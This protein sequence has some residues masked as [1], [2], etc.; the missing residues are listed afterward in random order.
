MKDG[1][2]GLQVE[3]GKMGR[4]RRRHSKMGLCEEKKRRLEVKSG[5]QNE[6]TL[7]SDIILY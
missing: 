5:F 4:G 1:K 7:P 3:L 2:T 6:K